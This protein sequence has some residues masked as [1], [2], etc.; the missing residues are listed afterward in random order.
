MLGPR[1]IGDFSGSGPVIS[2]GLASGSRRWRGHGQ[3]V[4]HLW[5]F[6]PTLRASDPARLGA[7]VMFSARLMLVR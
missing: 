3:S 1:F 2:R 6:A 5:G 7:N 4:R